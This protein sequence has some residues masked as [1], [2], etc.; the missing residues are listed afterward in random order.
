MLR[1]FEMKINDLFNTAIQIARN[2]DP[3][4]KKEIDLQ[5]KE[6]K[7]AYNLLPKEE[8]ERFDKESFRK[9]CNN[10]RRRLTLFH[11]LMT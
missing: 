6:L 8:K 7:D 3:R 10:T 2:N 4:D 9:K 11:I 1:F 5:L